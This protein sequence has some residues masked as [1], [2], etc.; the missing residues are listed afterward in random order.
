MS[1]R[2]C[3]TQRLGILHHFLAVVN[4]KLTKRVKYDCDS[5]RCGAERFQAPG[6]VDRSVCDCRR[7]S[8]LLFP[9]CLSHL[10]SCGPDLAS[11]RLFKAVADVGVWALVAGLLVRDIKCKRTISAWDR[12]G[13]AR[14]A[15]ESLP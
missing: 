15:P 10:L 13:C 14:T 6:A 1:C 2:F 9:L 12:R 8:R 7:R 11:S 5:G 4:L 3:N